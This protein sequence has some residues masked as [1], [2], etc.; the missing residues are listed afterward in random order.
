VQRTRPFATSFGKRQ[1]ISWRRCAWTRSGGHRSRPVR[2]QTGIFLGFHM[3]EATTPRPIGAVK[4]T[5]MRPRAYQHSE[6]SQPHIPVIWNRFEHLFYLV[7]M[8]S[9]TCAPIFAFLACVTAICSYVCTLSPS[10]NLCLDCDH[11]V[12]LRESQSCRD[13]SQTRTL[14]IRK[15]CGT[16]V[17]SLDHLR[18]IECN[19]RPLGC[20]N[21]E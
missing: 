8:W 3:K 6:T 4:K 20:H 17:W 11:F 21:V 9:C 18:G 12:R 14:E 2:S 7:L 1:S 16:Q 5:T 10:I 19:P 15:N 13:S